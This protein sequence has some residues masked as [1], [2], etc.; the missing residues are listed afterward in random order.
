MIDLAKLQTFLHVAQS[1]SFSEAATQLHLTQP[2]IS[3]HIK[4]LERD[5]GVELFDRSGSGLRL[6][7]AGSL[8]FPRARRLVREVFEIQQMMESLEDKIVGHLRIACSTTTGKYVL[9]QF[10]ARFHDQHPGVNISILRCTS[11]LVVPQLLREEADLGVVSYD[12]CGDGM[13]CQEFFNDHIILIVPAHHPW[14]L[15]QSIDPSDLLDIPMIIREPT[16]GTYRAMLAELGKH[17]I[18][19]DDMNI[20]LEVGNSEAI[21]KAVEADFGVAFVSR[22]AADWALDKGTV[23]EVPVVGFDLHRK[24]YLIRAEVH[25]PHR[26][27]EAFWGFVHDPSNADLLRLAE[28]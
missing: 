23:A 1:M 15:C 13:E 4:M 9:P 17:S 7:E 14:T 19:L 25:E 26:A 21:V 22:L 5:L 28:R 3:H 18:T 20:C 11:P 8:L 6:T 2:T 24:V 27:V 12:A 10:A 16:S